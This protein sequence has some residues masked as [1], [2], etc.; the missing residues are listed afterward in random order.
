LLNQHD[1]KRTGEFAKRIGKLLR[2]GR[3]AALTAGNWAM[4]AISGWNPVIIDTVWTTMP[5]SRASVRSSDR[6]SAIVLFFI[7]RNDDNFAGERSD[8]WIRQWCL[9]VIETRGEIIR[10]AF[11]EACK[12]ALFAAQA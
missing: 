8:I 2:V 1:W 9:S 10:R 11:N 5:A 12:E 3:L 6:I 7:G 4:A